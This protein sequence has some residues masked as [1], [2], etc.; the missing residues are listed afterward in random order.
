MGKWIQR[1]LQRNASSRGAQW[2]MVFNDQTGPGGH[3]YLA[4]TEQSHPPTPGLKYEAV[5]ARNSFTGG[6]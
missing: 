5:G 1:T 3:K 6:T 2:G 4:E